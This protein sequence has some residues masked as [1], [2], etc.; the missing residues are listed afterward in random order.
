MKK[1]RFNEQELLEGLD[2][3]SAQAEEL[4]T[5]L[6]QELTPLERLRGSVLHYD[7]PTDPIWD[8]S[9]ES[10]DSVADDFMQ[11]QEQ[12]PRRQD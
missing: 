10:H 6:P 4:T 2:S 3:E 5:P 1:K 11:D 9:F 7:R 8:E 12:P